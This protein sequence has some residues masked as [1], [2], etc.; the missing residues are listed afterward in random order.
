MSSRLFTT[1]REERGLCYTVYA[2]HHSLYDAARVFCYAGTTQERA[3]ETLDVMLTELARLIDGVNEAELSRLKA[4]TKS[5]LIMQQESSLS[6]CGSLVGDWYH[7]G[8]LRTMDELHA[9]IDA[10]SC[11]EIN[12]Y[13]REHPAGEFTVVTLGQQALEVR[14]GVS[15]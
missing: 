4:R 8:R 11:A 6:R 2:H 15:A 7:L 5:A 12:Q 9:K 3:Q 13:L 14:V 1:V 10:L